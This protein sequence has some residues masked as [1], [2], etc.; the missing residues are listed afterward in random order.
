MSFRDFGGNFTGSL[1]LIKTFPYQSHSVGC[2]SGAGGKTQNLLYVMKSIRL[3]ERLKNSLLAM[4]H[5]S[6]SQLPAG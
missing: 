5:R 2:R 4:I 3:P 1:P 6:Y